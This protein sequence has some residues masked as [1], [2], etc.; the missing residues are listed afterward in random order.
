MD[1]SSNKLTLIP[2]SLWNLE[3]LRLLNLS[4]N[5]LNGSLDPHKALEVL[6]SMDLSWNQISGNIPRIIGS[7]QRLASLNL[8]RNSFSG[9]IPNSIGNLVALD[10]LDLS[11]NN[12][13]GPIPKSLDALLLEMLSLSSL[14]SSSSLLLERDRVER[15]RTQSARCHFSAIPFSHTSLFSQMTSSRPLT[16]F[17]NLNDRMS[18][19]GQ[20]A[21]APTYLNLSTP[22]IEQIMAAQTEIEANHYTLKSCMETVAA[23]INLSHRLQNRTCKVHRVNAQLSA[24][25]YVQGCASRDLR[26]VGGE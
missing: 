7:F 10:F 18:S 26:I 21:P 16:L 15:D 3:N 2:S 6:E 5:S 12:L 22:T 17:P 23:V 1:I 11:L 24:P 4:F 25:A 20:S 13:S 8:S 14:S 9:P 19:L